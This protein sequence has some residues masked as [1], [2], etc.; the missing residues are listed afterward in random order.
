MK[1]LFGRI[2]CLVLCAFALTCGAA[3]AEPVFTVDY[4][5]SITHV[6]MDPETEALEIPDKVGGIEVR[7][8]AAGVFDDYPGL[9]YVRMN[10]AGLRTFA[11][12]SLDFRSA[13]NLEIIYIHV[14]YTEALRAKF[15]LGESVEV[16]Q[17][18]DP[19]TQVLPDAFISYEH[20]KA[21]LRFSEIG[22]AISIRVTRTVQGSDESVCFDSM[23]D[24]VRFSIGNGMVR[25]IDDTVEP[26][27]DYEY[28]IEGMNPFWSS[29]PSC[30]ARISIPGNEPEKVPEQ[31][32]PETGDGA[33][34]V[35]W[36][37]LAAMGA[38]GMLI[39][40]RKREA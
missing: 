22:S 33:N 8:I 14:E 32:L 17:Y 5:G 36:A 20:G 34:P 28:R 26:G 29:G 7:G 21:E 3:L 9:K 16:L 24:Y 27:F 10:A 23:R 39:T 25:F 1:K 11:N 30:V 37:A 4:D 15:K 13:E 2:F 18:V 19:T 40:R 35:L 38:A 31:P 6:A 12:G